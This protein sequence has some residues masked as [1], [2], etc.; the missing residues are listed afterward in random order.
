MPPM[1]SYTM[2]GQ[3]LVS[4]AE[5][6]LY[7]HQGC[8]GSGWAEGVCPERWKQRRGKIAGCTTTHLLNGGHDAA[9]PSQSKLHAC[10]AAKVWVSLG[11]PL[12]GVH[13]G[14]CQ[15]DCRWARASSI[16]E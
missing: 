13:P 15:L 11:L 7:H 12:C 5:T 14:A 4:G 3:R 1:M 8:C 10:P 16:P 6:A 2:A 9:Q